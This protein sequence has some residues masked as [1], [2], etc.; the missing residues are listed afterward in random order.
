MDKGGRSLQRLHE[1]GLERVLEERRHGPRSAELA[2]G[3]GLLVIGVAHHDAGEARLEVRDVRGEAEHGHDL[4]RDRDV[5]A[6]LAGDAVH[7]P[8]EAVGD[9]AQL[10][11]VHVHGAAPGDAPGVYVEGVALVDVVIQHRGEEV[12]RRAYGVEVAGEVEVDVLHGDDLGIAAAGRAA[13]Y[14]EHGPERG[15]AQCHDGAAAYFPQRVREAD[16]GRGLSL[17]RR[18]GVYG[19][20]EDELAVLPRGLEQGGVYL[21]LI[22]AVALDKALVDAGLGG[23]F[24]YGQG[25]GCLGNFNIGHGAPLYVKNPFYFTISRGFVKLRAGLQPQVAQIPAASCLPAKAVDAILE[26]V[27]YTIKCNTLGG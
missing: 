1:V 16:G 19:G 10:P 27:N 26:P 17:A 24:G 23:D 12:V 13:L 22:P 18:G 25:D 21:G 8:A 11:V 7:A 9:E 14:A 4:A 2:S 3:H 20:D 5:K 6:V 15:L